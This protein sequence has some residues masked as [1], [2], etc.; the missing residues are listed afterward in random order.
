MVGTVVLEQVSVARFQF[1]V[2]VFDQL[3][4]AVQHLGVAF[5]LCQSDAGHDVGHVTLEI[6]RD[7]VVFPCAQLRFGQCVFILSVQ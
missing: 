6:R 1:L 7:D 4:A 2:V 3:T 5:Q